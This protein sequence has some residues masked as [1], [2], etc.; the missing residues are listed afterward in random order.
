M[1]A[2]IFLHSD[3]VNIPHIEKIAIGVALFHDTGR[4]PDF[5]GHYGGFELN[6]KAVESQLHKLHIA[7]YQ[8]DWNLKSWQRNGS[9]RTSDNFVVY[10]QHFF[11]EDCFQLLGIVT[12]EAHAKIDSLL[13]AFIDKAEQFHC[14]RRTELL[15]QP[16]YLSQN[17]VAKT[18]KLTP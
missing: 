1:S 14:R 12:P 7:L 9:R 16:H 5:L 4:Y 11:C 17:N 8:S 2:H 15:E 6:P 10:T 13:T 18:I 3:L